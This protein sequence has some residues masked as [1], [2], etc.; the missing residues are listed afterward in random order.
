MTR[1]PRARIHAQSFSTLSTVVQRVA[2]PSPLE[3]EGTGG[4]LDDRR[5]TNDG[6]ISAIA[7]TGQ[8]LPCV[9]VIA[10]MNRYHRQS[11]LP[12]VGSAGQAK[13]G[14]ACALIVGCGALGTVI[15]EQLARAGVGRL[16]LIDRDIVEETNLQRQVLYDEEDVRES[17]PKAIAAFRR[18]SEINSSITI[19][20]QVADLH[21]GN[22]DE[23]VVGARADVIID[24]TDNV[25]TRYL[26]NDLSVKH[27]IPYIYGACVGTQGR[28]ATFGRTV[29]EAC[30]RCVF[31]EPAG[32]GEL[33]T[34]DTAGVLGPVASVVGS[35]QAIAAIKILSGNAAVGP[36][37][38]VTMDLWT[39]RIR[40]VSL[41]EA[42][43]ADCPTCGLRRFEFLDQPTESTVSL[44]GRNAMQILPERRQ[45]KM[46]FAK[47][48]EGLK[49]AGAVTTTA[50][51]LKCAMAD[52]VVLTVFSDGRMIA[53]GTTDAARVRSIYARYIGS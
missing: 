52:G 17:V 43:R 10:K 50:Y 27:A 47:I 11:I 33:P 45:M 37:E 22:G 42:K 28:V 24:G 23:I 34:C 15:A 40:S 19:E 7:E 44:C 4:A 5:W 35:M 26:L 36:E 3:G 21:S 51:F 38:L 1:P 48:A 25:Q 6:S 9:N 14:G 46:D 18:L 32:T 31:A 29:G 49:S 20:P 53:Q 16:V 12:Q 8:A 13:L 41:A 2:S 30:L 39:G